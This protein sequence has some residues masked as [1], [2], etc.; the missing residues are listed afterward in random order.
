ME[1][2]NHSTYKARAASFRWQVINLFLQFN[3]AKHSNDVTSQKED[4]PLV[5][6]D[7]PNY[8]VTD[9]SPP[10]SILT[11]PASRFQVN[12]PRKISQ[13]TEQV[14]E[15]AD[16]ARRDSFELLSL[17]GES[18]EVSIWFRSVDWSGRGEGIERD[19]FHLTRGLHMVRKRKFKHKHKV[20]VKDNANASARTK[21]FYFCGW[22]GRAFALVW[23]LNI[24]DASA[25]ANPELS[26]RQES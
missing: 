22:F 14:S 19:H 23:H 7:V 26:N 6:A 5:A 20:N 10:P 16:V 15:D 13:D 8:G 17:D 11:A 24:G 3:V 12:T 18:T 21:T 1:N 9:P 25:V 4:Q 2:V